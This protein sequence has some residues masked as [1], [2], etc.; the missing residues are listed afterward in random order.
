MGRGDNKPDIA[1]HLPCIST[2]QVFDA[3]ARKDKNGSS[4]QR[5]YIA[6]GT[7]GENETAI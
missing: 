2:I 5:R 3:K 6:L 4:D 1:A 7:F